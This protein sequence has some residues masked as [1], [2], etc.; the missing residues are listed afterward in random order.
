MGA[1]L[2]N[3]GFASAYLLPDSPTWA[4]LS[5]SNV[6]YGT[7]AGEPL[8]GGRPFSSAWFVW[9]PDPALVGTT[10]SIDTH[11]AGYDTFIGVYS[12]PA[13]D[14]SQYYLYTFSNLTLVNYNDD[15]N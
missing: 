2:H 3:D 1:D 7:E 11:G 9:Y 14:T 13:V 12:A 6:G 5:F 4:S 8:S 15:S 10:V